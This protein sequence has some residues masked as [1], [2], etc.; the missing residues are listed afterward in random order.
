MLQNVIS[1]KMLKKKTPQTNTFFLTP[2]N[3]LCITPLKTLRSWLMIVSP[4]VLMFEFSWSHPCLPYIIAADS[5]PAAEATA[6]LL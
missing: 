3:N 4:T 1:D 6:H 5:R 2:K